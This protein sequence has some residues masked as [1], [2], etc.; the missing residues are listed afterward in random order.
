MDPKS[1]DKC[2]Y[3]RREGG[4]QKQRPRGEGQVTTEA[5]AR[6]IQPRPRNTASPQKLEEAERILILD[7]GLQNGERINWYH[8]KPPGVSSFVTAAGDAHTP[9]FDL[10]L[11]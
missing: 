10:S 2:L 1:S 7:S 3:K 6:G 9:A 8:L 5:D 4:N 11:T